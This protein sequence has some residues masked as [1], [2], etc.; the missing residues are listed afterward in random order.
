[1][2]KTLT[3]GYLA[4]AAEVNIETVRYYQRVG[5]IQEPKKPTTGYRIYPNE[6][7]DRLKFIKRAKDLG[8]SLKEIIELLELGDGRCRDVQLRAEQKRTLID[9][10]ISDLKKLRKTLGNLIKTCQ[11]ETNK[12]HCPIVE[13]LTGKR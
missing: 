6:I 5:L 7:V 12:V 8:F 4:R 1:M 10:Q 13:T 3:I 9:Q 2:N 11:T